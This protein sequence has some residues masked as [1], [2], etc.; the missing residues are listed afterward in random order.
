MVDRA[1]ENVVE[2]VRWGVCGCRGAAVLL[3]DDKEV[4]LL[5]ILQH[6]LDTRREGPAARDVEFGLG[7]NVGLGPDLQNSG[8]H[9]IFKKLPDLS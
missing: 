9:T 6:I 8:M 2:G 1:V 5:R 4:R 7:H 3:A